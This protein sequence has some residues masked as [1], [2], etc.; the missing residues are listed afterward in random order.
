M[1]KKKF[2]NNSSNPEGPKGQKD[3]SVFFKLFQ[4]I[5][6]III[7]FKRKNRRFS[8]EHPYLLQSIQLT[9]IYFFAVLTLF[10]N[11]TALV[12]HIPYVFEHIIPSF[13]QDLIKSPIVRL[14]LA[15][16]K[17]YVVYLF[18]IEFIIFRSLFNFSKLF[19]FNVLLIILLEMIQNLA[20]SYWDI[21]FNRQF[22]NNQIL[23]VD[24]VWALFCISLIYLFFFICYLYS[25]FCSMRG[26]YTS[27]PYMDWLTDSISFWLRIRTPRMKKK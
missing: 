1:K 10:Y 18:V 27:I 11:L 16:E 21:F 26:K 5:K 14:A 24:M 17:T 4:W 12:G 8:K 9:F 2:S 7:L 23:N 6:R 22:G 15:P 25:Y 19:K 3:Q 13:L 20:I